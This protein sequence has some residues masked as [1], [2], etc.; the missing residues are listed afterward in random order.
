[1]NRRI[2][3]AW[4][5]LERALGATSFETFDETMTSG[6]DISAVESAWQAIEQMRK[7]VAEMKQPAGGQS[8]S[9]EGCSE[10]ATCLACGR[11]P[12]DDVIDDLYEIAPE[13]LFNGPEGHPIPAHYCAFH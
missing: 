9:F 6:W 8:C 10:P 4:Q 13:K 11:P 12:C 3:R 1:M 7:A 5:A 2:E